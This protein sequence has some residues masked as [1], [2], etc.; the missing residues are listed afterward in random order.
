MDRYQKYVHTGLCTIDKTPLPGRRV[1]TGGILGTIFTPSSYYIQISFDRFMECMQK[2]LFKNLPNILHF[3]IYDEVKIQTREEC[4]IRFQF[5]K[6]LK[7]FP[8]A[9]YEFFLSDS[10]MPAY[11]SF[12]NSMNWDQENKTTYYMSIDRNPI[13]EKRIPLEQA[14]GKIEI[15]EEK[16]LWF[17]DKTLRLLPG[18]VEHEVLTDTMKLK[19]FI[20]E[21]MN[22]LDH[23]YRIDCLND[24]DKAYITYHYLFDKLYALNIAITPINITYA[25]SQ[26]FRD[27][28]GTQRLKPSKTRWESKPAGTLEHKKGVCKGQARLLN[29]VLC[30][31]EIRIPADKISGVIP[32]GE[33][34]CWSHMVID[35]HIL[36]CCTTLRGLF[37]NLDAAGYKP[38][39]GQIYTDLYPHA[40]LSDQEIEKIKMKIKKCRK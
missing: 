28:W 3:R 31:P 13:T 22:K 19:R 18:K 1:E 33:H 11:I 40:H 34:H 27:A 21:Y 25:T 7:Q 29:S 37:K 16:L 30:S 4:L 12:M 6:Y 2:G 32:S 36:Q 15:P 17:P 38:N 9:T 10:S 8:N 23:T 20:H 14:R 39:E 26:T 35:H 5:L 24:F